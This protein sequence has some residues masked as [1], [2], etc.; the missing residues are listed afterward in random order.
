MVSQN[1]GCRSLLKKKILGSYKSDETFSINKD[2]FQ[3][4]TAMIHIF[5]YLYISFQ[6]YA[7]LLKK[8]SAEHS[9]RYFKI[10]N[11]NVPKLDDHLFMGMKI[12]H[13]YIHDCSK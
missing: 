2:L 9:I 5:F 11:S 13:L 12:E 1:L 7:R 4:F 10:R 8:N 3:I 6:Y